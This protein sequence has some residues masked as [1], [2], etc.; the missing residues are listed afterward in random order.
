M[1]D[2]KRQLEE[3]IRQRAYALWEQA[4]RPHGQDE[5]HWHQA[6]RELDAG[7]AGNAALDAQLADTFPASDPPSLTDP[8]RGARLSGD[9]AA[10]PARPAAKKPVAGTDAAPSAATQKAAA[11]AASKAPGAQPPAPAGARPTP[12]KA[13]PKPAARKPKA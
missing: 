2:A 1:S 9:K 6:R 3:R 13:A 12:G 11:A 10:K 4:G 8:N 5:A 7:E